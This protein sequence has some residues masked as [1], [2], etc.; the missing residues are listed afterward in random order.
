[1]I[2]FCEI[3]G[4]MLSD[5]LLCM[6]RGALVHRSPLSACVHMYFCWCNL[7]CRSTAMFS[8]QRGVATRCSVCTGNSGDQVHHLWPRLW[9]C[10]RRSLLQVNFLPKR[11]GGGR[12]CLLAQVVSS[13]P[14]LFSY[15]V[16]VVCIVCIVCIVYRVCVCVCANN[17]TL[18]AILCVGGLRR[19]FAP[20]W[21]EHVP[22]K[23]QPKGQTALIAMSTLL[24]ALFVSCEIE[25]Q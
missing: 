22:W 3:C 23:L 5:L 6:Q 4:A 20:F 17:S 18:L 13:R 2:R 25:P 12:F 11:G 9:L 1:M 21:I 16:C 10:Y 15:T 14:C 7:C 8:I 19:T 24:L